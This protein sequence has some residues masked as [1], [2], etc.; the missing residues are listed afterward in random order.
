[1]KA[2]FIFQTMQRHRENLVKILD[3][4]PES[5]LGH[6]PE[7]FR[8][9]IWWNI[10]H[11]VVVQQLL[12]YKL[13]GL[14]LNI[15]DDFVM[16]YSKGTFPGEL[17][18]PEKRGEVARL[19]VDTVGRLEQDY[20]NGIFKNYTTYK[21]SAGFTLRSIDEA[22]QF[23]LYHEGIHLGTVLSLLKIVQ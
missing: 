20:D 7:G 16:A 10:S 2:E 1:M 6:I 3:N 18:I 13:S 12:C 17:P 14:P 23:N 8:N 21:T 11:I 4:T 15:T 19:L 22:L 5:A 9:N